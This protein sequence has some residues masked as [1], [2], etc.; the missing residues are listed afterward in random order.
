VAE[1]TDH[2]MAVAMHWVARIIAAGLMMSV[3]G[4]GGRW[5]DGRLGTAFIAP[6]GFIVGLIG[7]MAYLIAATRAAE[8]ERKA[9]RNSGPGK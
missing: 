3:P 1:R 5:L 2:P 6:L 4:I 7:G 9:R 8:A